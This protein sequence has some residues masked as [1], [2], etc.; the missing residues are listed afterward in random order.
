MSIRSVEFDTTP[1]IHTLPTYLSDQPNQPGLEQNWQATKLHQVVPLDG[2]KVLVVA[3]ASRI[4]TDN[5]FQRLVEDYAGRV[6]DPF[7]QDLTAWTVLWSD[8]GNIKTT[9]NFIARPDGGFAML[10]GENIGQSSAQSVRTNGQ[11]TVFDDT[12]NVQREI[13]RPNA[14]YFSTISNGDRIYSAL[15]APVLMSGNTLYILQNITTEVDEGVALP[16]VTGQAQNEFLFAQHS[17]TTRLIS[18]NLSTGEIAPPITVGTGVGGYHWLERDNLR[19]DFERIPPLIGA[20][21]V[22]DGLG[23]LFYI[24]MVQKAYQIARDFSGDSEIQ[25]RPEIVAR[26]INADGSVGPEQVLRTLSGGEDLFRG[27]PGFLA[28]EGL[29][30]GGFALAWSNFDGG[31]DLQRFNPNLS[32]AG[33]RVSI[34]DV[35]LSGLALNDLGQLALSGSGWEAILDPVTLIPQM[36]NTDFPSAPVGFSDFAGVSLSGNSFD[37][38][39]VLQFGDGRYLDVIWQSSD[40]NNFAIFTYDTRSALGSL[41]G[42]TNSL[43]L[44]TSGTDTVVGTRNDDM[45]LTTAGLDVYVGWVGNDTISG[46]LRF[47]QGYHGY[48]PDPARQAEDRG[49]DTLDLSST[50]TNGNTVLPIYTFDLPAGEIR[51]RAPFFGSTTIPVSSVFSGIDTFIGTPFADHFII[52]ALPPS[53]VTLQ[54]GAGA[55]RLIYQGP[56]PLIEVDLGAGTLGVPGMTDVQ[57]VNFTNFREYQGGSQADRVMGSAGNDRIEGGSGNDTLTGGAGIDTLLGGSGLDWVD[58]ALDHLNPGGVA[59]NRGVVVDLEAGTATDTHGATDSLTGIENVIGTQWADHISV[60]TLFGGE[61][62]AGTGNDTIIGGRAT[63]HLYGDDGDDSILGG[64]GPDQ[65]FGG[66]GNDTLMGEA[67]NDTIFGGDGRDVLDGGDSSDLLNGGGS[68]DTLLG[69]DGDDTLLGGEGGDDLDGGEGDDR[70]NGN[71]GSDLIVGGNGDDLLFGET[72]NDTLLGG[73][74]RDMLR[75][76]SGADSLDGG[77]DNDTLE[78]GSGRDSLSGGSGNDSLDGGSGNDTLTG[79][80]GNDTLRGAS[81]NDVLEGNT[82]DDILDGGSGSD[83]LIG[84]AGDDTLTGG[85][86][87]DVFVFGDGFG[88]DIITDFQNGIDRFDFRQHGATNFAQLSVTNANGDATIADNAGNTVLVLDAAGL[89]DAGDFIF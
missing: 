43:A 76:G 18:V 26:Q 82:G 83:R 61:V 57:G 38:S 79:G 11:I 13:N 46:P 16:E 24:S 34:D 15:P 47:G 85:S 89:I 66:E 63:D 30:N 56:A 86:S 7:G 23:N 67:G 69:G 37:A 88:R 2:G 39:R 70:L 62:S 44:Q 4:E 78:G 52:G 73:A 84:G 71:T 51:W 35:G 22:Q 77:S 49:F 41:P 29:A 32:A 3:T 60:R 54:G 19:D 80:S 53:R 17:Y 75:G 10:T 28:A 58:Y 42:Q 55:N 59:G 81:D 72:G 12:L 9:P 8:T 48:H 50:V 74:N 33:T 1:I 40:P 68:A 5:G 87:A 65:L 64:D 14:D 25:Y 31:T 27:G 21:L 45:I 36:S 6:F 20:E